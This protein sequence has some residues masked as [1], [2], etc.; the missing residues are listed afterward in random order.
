MS[1]TVS[2]GYA[3]VLAFALA[4]VEGIEAALIGTTA[5]KQFG[6]RFY[7]VIIL[8]FLTAISIGAVVYFL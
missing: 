6:K 3:I 8:A 7:V 1:V 5:D 4:F 2:I